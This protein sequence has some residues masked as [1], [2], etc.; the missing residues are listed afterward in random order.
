MSPSRT[1]DWSDDSAGCRQE[2]TAN[3]IKRKPNAKRSTDEQFSNKRQKKSW[4]TDVHSKVED[5]NDCRKTKVSTS[6]GIRHMDNVSTIVTPSPGTGCKHSSKNMKSAE[7]LTSAAPFTSL[8]AI[9]CKEEGLPAGVVNIDRLAFSCENEIRLMC[10]CHHGLDHCCASNLTESY[11]ATYSQDHDK[12]LESA[13]DNSFSTDSV[14]TCFSISTSSAASP[15]SLSPPSTVIRRSTRRR[16]KNQFVGEDALFSYST[17]NV[18][19][20]D[21]CIIPQPN[22]EINYLSWHQNLSADTRATLIDWLIE[23]AGEYQLLD[24]TLHTAVGLVDRSL[25]RAVYLRDGESL[26]SSNGRS[27]LII[28]KETLQLLG[29]ACMIIAGKIHETSPPYVSDYT[30]ISASNYSTTQ[31][32]DMELNICSALHF[33]FHVV[34]PHNFVNRLS[35]A[36]FASSCTLNILRCAG[37]KNDRMDY[38][39]EYFL[40][41]AMLY[42]KYVLLKPSL[43]A[44]AAV[45]LARATLGITDRESV[46]IGFWSKTLEYYSGYDFNELES[47]VRHLHKAHSAVE[48]GEYKTVY[49]KFAKSDTHSVSLKTVLAAD[50]LGFQ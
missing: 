5:E 46:N 4:S 19:C 38:M 17:I 34:T 10:S 50:M 41:I 43:V 3:R 1:G 20:S 15:L 44:A 22:E 13:E 8:D 35:R 31:V 28:N 24:V 11:L 39:V 14:S 9:L 12:Y 29:C 47:P 36:S 23:V 26:Q 49:K 33:R 21:E 32:T 18:K 16:R 6:K 48:E 25:A 45:Y 7:S 2:C 40:E 42:Y 37:T 27:A 30:Y